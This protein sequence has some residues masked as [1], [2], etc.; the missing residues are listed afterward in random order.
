MPAIVAVKKKSEMSFKSSIRLRCPISEI[1]TS[2]VCR[3]KCR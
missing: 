3:L 1:A 2:R